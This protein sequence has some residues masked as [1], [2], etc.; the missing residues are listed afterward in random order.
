M[1]NTVMLK[2]MLD[3]YNANAYAHKYIMGFTDRKTV[4]MAVCGED[5][6]PYVCTL[7]KASRGAGYALR[8]CPNKEQKEV[9]KTGE[10]VALC[11]ADYFMA[12]VSGSKYNKGE[13][14]EKLVTEHFGQKWVKDN[15]PYT[16]A[17]D[18]EVDGIPYQIKYE[19]A[20]FCNEKS[21]ANLAK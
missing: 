11:S 13:I 21:L 20:T 16:M 15:I 14:F 17:G 10:L 2:T 9:L 19:K 5:M 1:T 3:R 4:Y 18:I 8:F 7:D 12:L 6:L